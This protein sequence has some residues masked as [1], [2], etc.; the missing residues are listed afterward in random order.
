MI[1]VLVGRQARITTSG[2]RL[3][4]LL[5]RVERTRDSWPVDHV[6]GRGHCRWE[7]VPC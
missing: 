5:D 1:F 6:G 4:S 7:G 2:T 3:S